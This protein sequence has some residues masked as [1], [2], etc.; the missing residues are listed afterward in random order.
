MYPIDHVFFILS[1]YLINSKI[2]KISNEDLEPNMSFFAE[3][4]NGL[5]VN[6]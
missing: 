5:R 2:A 6:H 4:N 3:K 1:E